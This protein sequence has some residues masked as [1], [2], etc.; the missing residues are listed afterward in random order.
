MPTVL[1]VRGH[2]FFFSSNEGQEPPHVHV[3][4]ADH[5]AK[6][7][8]APVALAIS[9]GYDASELRELREIVVQHREL[10]E[11]RWHEYFGD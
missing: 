10:L 11:E 7:W 8:L 4:T 2:R 6:F 1:R 9:V 3:E 5:Y